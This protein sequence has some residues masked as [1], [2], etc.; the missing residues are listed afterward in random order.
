MTFVAELLNYALALFFWLILGRIALTLL[1]H[2]RE[3]FF[4]G[5][6][7]KGTEPVFGVVRRLT[8]NRVGERG[9]ALL[10]LLL[11]AVLRIALVPVLRG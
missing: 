5:V 7:V 11:L 6:F 9:V 8:G 2:G 3:G 1:T 10:S 4:M